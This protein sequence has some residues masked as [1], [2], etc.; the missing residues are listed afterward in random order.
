MTA[1]PPVADARTEA[2]RRWL[3]ALMAEPDRPSSEHQDATDRPP[4]QS[5][6]KA[7]KPAQEDR[8]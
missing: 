8:R 4:P 3:R 5:Q 2:W 6:P 1:S 7:D